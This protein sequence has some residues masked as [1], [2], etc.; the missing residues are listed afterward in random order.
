MPSLS[1]QSSF[2][3][4]CLSVWLSA[5]WL[6]GR[7]CGAMSLA[8]CPWIQKVKVQSE[9]DPDSKDSKG[10]PS[11]V[12]CTQHE[13]NLKKMT[14]DLTFVKETIAC[15]CWYSWCFSIPLSIVILYWLRRS[16]AAWQKS[17]QTWQVPCR[18]P[19]TL[20]TALSARWH[21]RTQRSTCSTQKPLRSGT[22]NML[23]NGLRVESTCPSKGA[24]RAGLLLVT[25]KSNLDCP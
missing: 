16:W 23:G 2:G 3:R 13:K 4:F 8:V 17:S 24:A 19:C 5:S 7:L 10:Q 14:G 1:A 6:C 22:R 15:K 9:G 18:N 11:K 21:Q 12:L 25:N 20:V